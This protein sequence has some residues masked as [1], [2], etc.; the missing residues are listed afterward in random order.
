MSPKTP[1]RPG[2]WRWAAL[3]LAVVVVIPAL[4]AL[5]FLDPAHPD[6]LSRW[7]L[8]ETLSADAD[9]PL[10][11]TH[12][13]VLMVTVCTLRKDRLG[14]G[15]GRNPTSPFLDQLADKGVVFRRHIAQAPW[16]RPSMGALYSGRWPRALRLDSPGRGE[17]F[18]MVLAD[19]HTLLA[20]HLQAQDYATVAA[21]GNPNLQRQFGF[22]QGFDE[23]SQPTRTYSQGTHTPP[24][25][26]LVDDVLNMAAAVPLDRRL[27]ARVV[28]LDGHSPRQWRPLHFRFMNGKRKGILQYDAALRTMD[29]QIARLV[30]TLRAERPNLLVM[31]TADHG[32]GLMMPRHHGPGHGNKLFR[33][34]IEVPWVVQHPSLPP[35][36]VD[37][38][39]MNID[40]AP[41]VLDLL[42]AP[43][44]P[45]HDGT[46]QRA[47]LFGDPG[48]GSATEDGPG[49][50]FSETF[51]RR[52]HASTVLDADYQLV[53]TYERPGTHG[54][55][56]NALY[57]TADWRADDDVTDE[58]PE[59]AARLA[60]RL[61]AWEKAQAAAAE[62]AG[63][64]E[65]VEVDA[66]TRSALQALGYVE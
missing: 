4:L 2:R 30:A 52:A 12:T 14:F 51:F 33:T 38:L 7:A 54:P 49:P 26:E 57:T 31:L 23:Y 45:A 56:S 11:L 5:R 6:T 16:T 62:A 22:A 46:S 48:S 60:A 59:V 21:V 47:A 58:F 55:F 19:P 24:S 20:E 63:P 66:H 27:Y 36:T 3:V 28:M 35:R 64:V 53:R 61:T 32:E 15:G 50:A 18:D 13:D 39:S 37:T 41:T 65:T 42:G 17:R 9:M 8:A 10:D 44:D 34:T 40:V 29:A 43:A 25:S 1:R